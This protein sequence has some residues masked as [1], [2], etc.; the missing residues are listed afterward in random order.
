MNIKL[1]IKKQNKTFKKKNPN[2][3]KTE[4]VQN[5]MI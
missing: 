5:T 1:N 3:T 2:K 4:K